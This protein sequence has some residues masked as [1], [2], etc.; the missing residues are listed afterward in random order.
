MFHFRLPDMDCGGCV[1]KVTR[2]VQSVDPDA[3]VEADLATRNVKIKTTSA[4][5]DIVEALDEAGYEIEKL[6]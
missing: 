5:A 2:A 6:G 1:K 3:T 4:E